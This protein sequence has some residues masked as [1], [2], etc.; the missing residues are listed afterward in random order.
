[1]KHRICRGGWGQRYETVEVLINKG[2]CEPTKVGGG[3]DPQVV[4]WPRGWMP[5]ETWGICSWSDHTSDNH[6]CMASVCLRAQYVECSV[7]DSKAE[8]EGVE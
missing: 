2:G 4:A 3:G 8:E 5:G 1:M 7:V 6:T